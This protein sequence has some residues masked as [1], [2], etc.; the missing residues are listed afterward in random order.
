MLKILSSIRDQTTKSREVREQLKSC[1]TSKAPYTCRYTCRNLIPN[2][3]GISLYLE[4]KICYPFQPYPTVK[5]EYLTRIATEMK[6]KICPP[7]V[8][9]ILMLW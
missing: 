8:S 7:N 3:V 1:E 4:S 5:L 9:K 6:I 2:S